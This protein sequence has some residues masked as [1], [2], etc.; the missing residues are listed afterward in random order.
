MRLAVVS[1]IHANLE[2][3]QAVL[4]DAE[5]RGAEGY[6]G[7]GDFIGFNG[8]PSD[9]VRRVRP[10]LLL[11][12]RGNHEQALRQKGFFGVPLYESM[13]EKTG[14]ML[15]LEQKQWLGQLP[16]KVAWHHCLWVHA[17]PSSETPWR[18]LSSRRAVEEAFASFQE[19][20]CFF[21]HTHRTAIFCQSGDRI[22]QLELRPDAEGTCHLALEPGL[23][24]LINPGS[25]GQPRDGDWRASYL[26]FDTEA[27]ELTFRRVPYRA[28][29]AAAK[30]A[31][32]GLPEYFARALKEGSSPTG[33]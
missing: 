5:A 6:A 4:E 24:Y 8:D 23:R 16:L 19:P 30:I 32:T 15:T 12:V 26:L 17:S 25:V 21:G 13:I 14:E 27:G 28:D 11:A 31:R 2:A 3:L 29:Q 22:R 33:D 20:I 9:C 7:L 18:R 1:D 10:R